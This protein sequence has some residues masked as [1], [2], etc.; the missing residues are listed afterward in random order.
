MLKAVR[1][2][3]MRGALLSLDAPILWSD[4]TNAPGAVGTNFTVTNAN[5]AAAQFFRLKQP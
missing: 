5:S 2:A 4:S 3:I 1:H